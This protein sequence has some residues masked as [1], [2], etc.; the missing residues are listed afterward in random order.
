MSLVAATD[1]TRNIAR[2]ARC[3]LSLAVVSSQICISFTRSS[4]VLLAVN[5][6]KTNKEEVTF[7][8]SFFRDY[9]FDTTSILQDGY[10]KSNESFSF[11]VSARLIVMLFRRMDPNSVNYIYLG[12]DCSEAAPSLKRFKLNVEIFTKKQVLKKYQIG[13]QPAQFAPTDIPSRYASLHK[14]GQISQFSIEVTTLKQFMDMVPGSSEDFG[15]EAKLNKITFRAY[16][17]HTSKETD[18]LKQQMLISI[19]M[20]VD[21]LPLTT[22]GEINIGIN[23]RLKDFRN[24]INLISSFKKDLRLSIDYTDEEAAVEAFF[25]Q[26]GDPILFLFQENGATVSL[27]QITAKDGETNHADEQT[28]RV[29]LKPPVVKSYATDLNDRTDLPATNVYFTGTLPAE[30]E[31]NENSGLFESITYG[32]LEAARGS[33]RPLAID[34]TERE[35]R[36]REGILEEVSELGPTQ[37]H[38]KPKSLFD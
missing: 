11:V 12:V 5:S 37:V 8:S 26:P 1:Q 16:S 38:Q 15:I 34:Y 9:V 6:A 35:E 2:F 24:Y 29:F 18:Y 19:L 28:K 21:E 20:A 22:L 30:Q 23:F 33:K 13:F 4:L 36:E 14:T 17:K 10:D 7:T 32:H 3:F 31:E 25:V 27:I